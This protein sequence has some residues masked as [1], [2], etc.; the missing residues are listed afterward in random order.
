MAR[1]RILFRSCSSTTAS[2]CSEMI[3]FFEC[4]YFRRQ[5]ELEARTK[6]GR[7]SSL[8]F[9]KMTSIS[10]S[11]QPHPIIFVFY[12]KTTK[13]FENS[14][15]QYFEIWTSG[16][17]FCRPLRCSRSHPRARSLHAGVPSRTAQSWN[18]KIMVVVII[19]KLRNNKSQKM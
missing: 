10:I 9:S 15:F 12:F 13:L 1:T 16:L 19:S 18:L 6:T 5:E 7:K 11:I 4:F 14:W 2:K 3:Q 8:V 17:L